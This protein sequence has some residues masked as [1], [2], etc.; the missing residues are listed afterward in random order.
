TYSE[1]AT[2]SGCR[3]VG[4]AEPVGCFKSVIRGENCLILANVVS[5]FSYP[6]HSP[7]RW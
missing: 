3:G 4:V 2:R 5:P 1:D 6:H 7:Q